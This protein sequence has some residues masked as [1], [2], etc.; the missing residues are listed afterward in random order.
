MF[1]RTKSHGLPPYLDSLG[2][3][4][5]L[6]GLGGN[7]AIGSADG[8]FGN[9]FTRQLL[10]S[11]PKTKPIHIDCD[12]SRSS[13]AWNWLERWMAAS[14]QELG[15]SKKPCHNQELNEK[16]SKQDYTGPEA[17]RLI[18]S[19]VEAP[20]PNHETLVKPTVNSIVQLEAKS[21]DSSTFSENQAR[22]PVVVSNKT[23][24]LPVEDA[25]LL[26]NMG[27]IEESE[28]SVQ[29]CKALRDSLACKMGIQSDETS[30][31]VLDSVPDK[32]RAE[33]P[34]NPKR[35]MKRA[36]PE[37]LDTENKRLVSMSRRTRSTSPSFAAVQS[38]FE[39]LSS[40]PTSVKPVPTISTSRPESPP[41]QACSDTKSTTDIALTDDST[42]YI[43]ILPNETFESSSQ[44][45][46]SPAL[47]R[48]ETE[49]WEAL[50]DAKSVN[51]GYAEV[52]SKSENLDNE[53]SNPPSISNSPA[54]TVLVEPVKI[55]GIDDKFDGSE[56]NQFTPNINTQVSDL[57]NSYNSSPEGSP[58]STA[59]A[60]ESLGTPLSQISSRGQNSGKESSGRGTYKGR[61]LVGKKSPVNQAANGS[62]ARN[63]VDHQPTDTKSG[64][65]RSSFGS[66]KLE[67]DNVEHELRS[68]PTVPGYMQATESARAKALTSSPKS[69]P[70]VQ[71]KA[72]YHTVKRHSLPGS[73]GRT[74][75]SGSP[76]IQR[77]LSQAQPGS[78]GKS[79][80][81]AEKAEWRR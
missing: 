32:P 49:G 30:T 19:G 1:V 80:G 36:A 52:V 47:P 23:S 51:D 68:S 75:S 14:T 66:T 42:S 31:S 63:S 55:D 34:E 17:P 6:G 61:S 10:E 40:T 62:N 53:A 58:I 44:I 39:E 3:E 72:N 16:A 5:G 25:P 41:S 27:F 76:R 33:E 45:T 79:Q 7:G 50:E 12:P 65:R 46:L 54:P 43:S 2:D 57:Q 8:V 69:S 24:D 77:S 60:P 18:C 64:R 67:H 9:G 74:N 22:D 15:Q 71:D 56:T 29:V 70:D 37:P 4:E 20:K 81:T 26:N 59:T 21:A 28:N 11:A 78:K 35:T 73:G 48:N 38:K 13:S